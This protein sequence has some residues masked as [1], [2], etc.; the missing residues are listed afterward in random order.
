MNS[1][2]TSNLKSFAC[3]M[4]ALAVTVV[5][6]WSF[7]DATSV[8]RGTRDRAAVARLAA[9]SEAA[10]PPGQADARVRLN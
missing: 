3:I 4:A 10:A 6:S 1:E 9:V 8:L 7:I 2:S 5:V